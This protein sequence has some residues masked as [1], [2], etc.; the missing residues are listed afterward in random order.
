[1]LDC[2]EVDLCI[3][4]KYKN[5]GKNKYTICFPYTI[6]SRVSLEFKGYSFNFWTPVSLVVSKSS[7]ICYLVL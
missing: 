1:M 6:G 7:L 2:P 5:N 3:V 4:V